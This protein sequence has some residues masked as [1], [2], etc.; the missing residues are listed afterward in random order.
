MQPRE[1]GSAAAELKAKNIPV[2]LGRVLAL[3][4]REDDPYDQAFTLPLKLTR[5]G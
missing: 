4:A 1:F 5:P 3:P 2:I